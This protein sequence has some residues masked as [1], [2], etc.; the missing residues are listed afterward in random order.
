MSAAHVCRGTVQSAFREMDAL[1]VN[2]EGQ[3][4]QQILNLC[5]PVDTNN[6][7]DVGILFQRHID[8]LIEYLELHQ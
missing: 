4:L 2:G 7:N 6:V 5:H 3:R 1:V 8:Y